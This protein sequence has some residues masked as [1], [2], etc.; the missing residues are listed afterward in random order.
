M[1]RYQCREGLA[2]RNLPLIRCQ[3]NGHW[4]RPQISCVPRRPVSARGG[5]TS[6]QELLA[7]I[8]VLPIIGRVTLKVS[9]PVS[10]S[11]GGKCAGCAGDPPVLMSRHS[12]KLWAPKAE[13]GEGLDELQREEQAEQG[14]GSEK[15]RV[16]P[17]RRV[18]VC[19]SP[20]PEL[21]APRRPQRDVRR[22]HWDAGKGC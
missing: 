22:D 9:L 3:E 10:R 1:L 21:C 15:R 7:P 18:S 8:L 20:R 19:A 12:A 11:Q 16:E 2:Q 14:A 6:P 5:S 4:E 13:P 17:R